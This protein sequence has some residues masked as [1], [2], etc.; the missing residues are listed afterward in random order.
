MADVRCLSPK[1]SSEI[2]KKE[3]RVFWSVFFS[4]GFLCFVSFFLSKE[5][6]RGKNKNTHYVVVRDISY[7]VS[8]NYNTLALMYHARLMIVMCVE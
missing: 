7:Y 6:K 2:Q 4:F 5:K 3:F 8:C 1:K